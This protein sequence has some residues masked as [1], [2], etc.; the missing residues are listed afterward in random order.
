MSDPLEYPDIART[1]SALW[2]QSWPVDQ[3]PA[4]QWRPALGQVASG[5]LVDQLVQRKTT[6]FARGMRLYGQIQPQI[7]GIRVT[8]GQATVIDCQDDSHA[9][10]ADASG[11]PKTV[12]VAGTPVLGTLTRTE[13]GWRVTH[14][15]YSGGR[16]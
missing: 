12:G 3:L 4:S 5:P 1:W 14:I 11:A 9:G 10:Q 15:D 2:S 16:C 8:D 6:D 13:A 7:T